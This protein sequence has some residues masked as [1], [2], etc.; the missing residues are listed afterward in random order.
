[1]EIVATFVPAPGSIRRRSWSPPS[2]ATSVEL[3]AD[4]LNGTSTSRRWWR[5][6]AAGG[7]DA[8]LPRRGGE[9][10]RAAERRRFFGRHL[11]RR[12]SSTSRRPATASCVDAVV[13]RDRVILSAHFDERRAR[14]PRTSGRRRCSPRGRGSSRSSRRRTTLADVVA[15]LHLAQALD[16]ASRP[17]RRAVVFATG[18][19][20]RATR[21]LGPLLGA[22]L[23]YAAW[24]AEQGAAPGQYLP[25]EMLALIGHLAGRPRRLFAVLGTPVGRVAVAARARR[26]LPRARAAERVRAPRGRGAGGAGRAA[27]SGGRVV[28]RRPRVPGGRLRGDD[29]VEGGGGAALHACWR[30]GPSAPRPPTRCCRAPG[31]VLGDCTDIDGITRV[32]AEEGVELRG[33]AGAR[34][35]RRRGGARGG[36]GAAARGRAGGD[37]RA[38]RGRAPARRR[39]GSGASSPRSEAS[40]RAA[41]VV[42]ATPAG[43]DGDAGRRGSRRCGSPRGGVVVDLPY[44]AGPTFLE[45]LAAGAGLALRRAAARCCSSRRSRSSRR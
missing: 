3:R 44:G 15:V 20:G 11:S 4:L 21:L 24:D 10:R 40:E 39:P 8:A 28:P 29:A 31:K 34:A 45:Q 30:R 17:A 42:N 27:A 19:A 16:S 37:R 32:L 6:R 14:R 23:A 25:E 43:A 36:G 1:M 9:A 18:E 41:V 13:P 12:R 33:I 7:G 26:R 35:R 5:H 38:R 22:P 2:G